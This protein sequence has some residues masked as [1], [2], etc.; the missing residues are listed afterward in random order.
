MMPE[1]LSDVF[2]GLFVL[3]C[4]GLWWHHEVK[5]RGLEGVVH[6]I[7]KEKDK[8]VAD[9]RNTLIGATSWENA[10]ERFSSNFPEPP[11]SDQ[12]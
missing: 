2:V 6:E 3:A 12:E 8:A 4:L 7:R 1:I 11:D 10:I 5:I 9:I